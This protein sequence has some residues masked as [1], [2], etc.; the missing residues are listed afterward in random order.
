MHKRLDTVQRRFHIMCEYHK[1][2]MEN[3]FFH[4]FMRT[5]LLRLCNLLAQLGIADSQEND[6][7]KRY[8]NK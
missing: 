8:L 4:S 6:K 7:A 2:R 1:H 5:D 3:S